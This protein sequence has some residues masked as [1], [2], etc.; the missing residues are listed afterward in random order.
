MEKEQ[1]CFYISYIYF[2]ILPSSENFFTYSSLTLGIPESFL[3]SK[4][5]IVP[6]KYFKIF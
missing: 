6:L 3:G 2:H 4:T 1:A 5:T